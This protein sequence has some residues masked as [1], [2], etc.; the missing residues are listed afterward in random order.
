MKWV[1]GPMAVPPTLSFFSAQ[2]FVSSLQSSGFTSEDS[3]CQLLSLTPRDARHTHVARVSYGDSPVS[4]FVCIFI[5]LESE[6]R[7]G[8][9]FSSLGLRGNLGGKGGW[10]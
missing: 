2:G 8:L 7:P 5:Y 10:Q 9:A 1:P 3:H 6:G 4:V